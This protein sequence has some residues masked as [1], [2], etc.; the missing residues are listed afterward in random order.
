MGALGDDQRPSDSGHSEGIS[1]GAPKDIGLGEQPIHW[2]FS[3][4]LSFFIF[5]Y[6]LNIMPFM[7]NGCDIFL[8]ILARAFINFLFF[9]EECLF[10]LSVFHIRHIPQSQESCLKGSC[11]RVGHNRTNCKLCACYW[12]PLQGE[13]K[14]DPFGL[15]HLGS[16]NVN[17]F[18]P[19]S[20]DIQIL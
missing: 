8:R 1:S 4:L 10:G 5:S 18:D 15:F 3:H 12:G 17:I 13:D 9:Y 7:I 2:S 20:L 14:G 11:L 19:F 16:S 6:F